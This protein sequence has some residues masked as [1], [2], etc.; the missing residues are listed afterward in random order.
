M[1]GFYPSKQLKEMLQEWMERGEIP[2]DKQDNYSDTLEQCI[3]MTEVFE[4]EDIQKFLE[5]SSV[6]N[7]RVF[8]HSNILKRFTNQLSHSRRDKN[9]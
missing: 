6:F 7:P 4:N 1:G 9:D 2:W 8:P 5:F 3:A